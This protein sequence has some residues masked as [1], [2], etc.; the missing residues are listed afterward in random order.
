MSSQGD[1][2]SLPKSTSL[3]IQTM[4]MV[5]KV[6]GE[7]HEVQSGYTKGLW[8]CLA[9]IL[10]VYRRLLK[11]PEAQRELLCRKNVVEI[12]KSLPLGKPLV[13]CSTSSPTQ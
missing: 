4:A 2:S 13:Y 12:G 9:R 10:V 6:S 3:S 11:D 1:T 8:R 5:E 7:Y